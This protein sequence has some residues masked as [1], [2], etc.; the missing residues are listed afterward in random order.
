[1]KKS[2]LL[3]F[4]FLMFST[5]CFAQSITLKGVVTDD[6][7]YPLESATVYLTSVKDST[8]VDY[9]ITK[10]NGSWEM[11]TRKID[12]PVYLK[13]SF[14]GMASYTKRFEILK[15]DDDF[16]TIVLKDNATELSEVVI[17]GEVPPIR[18]KSDTLE[19][20]ASSFKVRPDANV[21]ELLKQ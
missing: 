12:E 17:K 5:F 11:K 8:V 6:T 14:I 7:N 21:K 2:S 3:L 18:I 9:T 10:K 15:A 1:M 13:I 20:N 16:G 19:F 4:L